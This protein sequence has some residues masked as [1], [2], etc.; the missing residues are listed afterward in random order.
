MSERPFRPTRSAMWF[1]GASALVGGV[2]LVAHAPSSGSGPLS[3]SAAHAED[4]PAFDAGP[5]AAGTMVDRLQRFRSGNGSGRI[6]IDGPHLTSL[7]RHA[8]PALIPDGVTEPSVYVEDGIVRVHVHVSPGVLPGG[9]HL[10]DALETLPESVEVELRGRVVN[11]GVA[12]LAYRVE[13]VRVE[14][15]ELPAPVVALVLGAIQ[16]LKQAPGAVGSDDGASDA[17]S[18]GSPPGAPVLRVRW[19]AEL[20]TVRVLSDRIV[21]E[22]VEPL[23]ARAVDGSGGA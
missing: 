14:G 4:A 9:R 13:E 5:T 6:E 8:M 15:V 12:W 23:P 21:L 7:V 22:R 17:G 1:L 11:D 3:R 18:V 20:G 10:V 2:A 19:A 16:S